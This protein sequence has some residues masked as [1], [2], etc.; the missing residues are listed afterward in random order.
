MPTL[1]SI[2]ICAGA[3][4][5]ALGLDMAGFGHECLVEID[6][7]ACATLRINRP[8]WKVLHE[9]L[10]EFDGRAYKGIDLL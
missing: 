3:G 7:D 10:R 1:T 2:E 8:S 6:R 5:Q 9:D 4:G